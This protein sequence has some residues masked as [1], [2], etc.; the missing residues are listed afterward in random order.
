MLYSTDPKKLK[1][2]RKA[3]ARMLESHLEGG[4]R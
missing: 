4:I 2:R 3:Q 1:T